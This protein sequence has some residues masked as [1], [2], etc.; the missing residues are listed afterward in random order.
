MNHSQ[1]QRRAI[2]ETLKPF[3]LLPG[4]KA[5]MRA[6]V[7]LNCIVPAQGVMVRKKSCG[8]P[9]AG[10]AVWIWEPFPSKLV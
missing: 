1:I 5:G 10:T 3:L 6:G 2:A 9:G 7:I 4:E 8:T